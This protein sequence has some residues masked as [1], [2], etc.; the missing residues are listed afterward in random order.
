M[1]A[2]VE[3]QFGKMTESK[4][5]ETIRSSG[6]SYVGGQKPSSVICQKTI[7]ALQA[8]DYKGIGN[9]YA[10]EGKLIICLFDEDV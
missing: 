5:A 3:S 2:Y 6:G 4:T 8:R 10:M 1:K 7:G 9:Q